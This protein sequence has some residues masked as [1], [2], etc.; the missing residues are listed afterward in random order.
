MAP[1]TLRSLDA[2]TASL[3][4]GLSLQYALGMYVNLFVSFPEHGSGGQAWEFA[5]TEAPLVSHILLAFLLFFGAIALCIRAVR[6]K[7]TRWIWWAAIGLLGILMA[8][9][10]GAEFVASQSD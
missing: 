1:R 10:S 6:L 2:H 8:G 5:L 7:D 4:A 9:L 3:L